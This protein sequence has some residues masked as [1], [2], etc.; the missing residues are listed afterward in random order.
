[1]HDVRIALDLHVLGDLDAAGDGD[2]AGVVAPEIEQLQMLGALFRVGQQFV[3][4]AHVVFARQPARA[5]AG[6]RPQ[7]DV[8]AFE[9][10][11]YLG[12]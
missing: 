1:M 6:N 12:R 9:P 11:Q 4:Q 3:G 2:A 7:G 8:V 10:D 5:G